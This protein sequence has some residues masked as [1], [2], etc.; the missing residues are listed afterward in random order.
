MSIAVHP[1]ACVAP[2]HFPQCH[3]PR[4]I[5]DSGGASSDSG[6][7]SLLRVPAIAVVSL[8]VMLAGMLWIS[9]D[10]ILEPHLKEVT[11]GRMSRSR[12]FHSPRLW[13]RSSLSS[14]WI[15][16]WYRQLDSFY[17]QK[18]AKPALISG[19][20]ELL[21]PHKTVRC[22]KYCSSMP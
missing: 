15:E 18:L 19:M 3:H 16:W 14:G 5:A 1:L 17:W 20:D 7:V 6:L 4:P 13:L 8:S 22:N 11:G 12:L 9:L 21:H 2:D 10:P